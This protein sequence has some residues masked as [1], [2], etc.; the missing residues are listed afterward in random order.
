MCSDII[1]AFLQHPLN[2]LRVHAM[3]TNCKNITLYQLELSAELS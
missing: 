2:G 3:I 1:T